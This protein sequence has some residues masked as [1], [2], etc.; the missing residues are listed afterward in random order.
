M[1][2][3]DLRIGNWVNVPREDQC[4]FRID[5]IEY[6]TEQEGNVAMFPT[7]DGKIDKSVHPLTWYLKDL[8]PIPL[9]P[10][11]LLKCGFEKDA[12]NAWNISIYP[13]TGD[14]RCKGS[15]VLSF[16]G[17]YLYITE[18]RESKR[19]PKDDICTLWNKALRKE[20]YLHELQN[21]Y[22]VLV[23]KELKI[24]TEI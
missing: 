21:L 3:K 4:P 6:L 15:K 5:S 2:A 12:W 7:I 10:E 18:G 9:T 19:A 13:F 11:I 1:Q 16:S 22:Y 17:D 20:F 24:C 8:S 23:G 14:D